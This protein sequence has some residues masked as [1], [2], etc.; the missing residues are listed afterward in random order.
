MSKPTIT[1]YA[2]LNYPRGIRVNKEKGSKE[3][4]ETSAGRKLKRAIYVFCVRHR[5]VEEKQ[6]RV[7]CM[8]KE[9]LWNK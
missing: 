8:V 5:T 1:T 9:E 6:L 7:Y 3:G 4:Y 2:A